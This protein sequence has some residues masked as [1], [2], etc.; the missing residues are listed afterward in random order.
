MASEHP[1]QIEN[2]ANKS[3]IIAVD[4]ANAAGKGTISKR[5]ADHFGFAYLDTGLLYRAIGY[6]IET[7]G[8]NYNS[9]HDIL[10]AA[11]EPLTEGELNNPELKSEIYGQLAS[12]IGVHKKLREIL[13]QYQYNFP[14][15]KP[16]AVLDGRDIGTF[17]FPNADIKLFVTASLEE[18]AKR[19]YKELQ[20]RG[21]NI[22]YDQVLEDIKSR[23]ERDSTREVNPC[24]MAEDAFLVDTSDLSSEEASDIVIQYINNKLNK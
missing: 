16:G 14:N 1:P 17:I 9:I 19:R 20:S 10:H 12:I 24:L 11:E 3:F 6:R 13:D 18:R 23:E 22:I 15:G 8:L 5:I 2:S 7:M 21:K 4:G